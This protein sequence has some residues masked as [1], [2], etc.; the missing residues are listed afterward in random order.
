MESKETLISRMPSTSQPSFYRFGAVG[1]V[2]FAVDA[3]TFTLLQ[4]WLHAPHLSRLGAFL[5]AVAATYSLNKRYTF[6]SYTRS[7]PAIYLVGQTFS[8][9]INM[10]IFSLVIW[11]PIWLPAQYYLGLVLGSIAAMFLN[12][13][14]S[15][16]YAF[17]QK[18]N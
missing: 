16:R 15:R 18:T 2:G 14:L 5:V 17:G 11:N 3:G 4:G 1:A 10:S 6:R 13:E 7:R 12:Y 8:L 9:G